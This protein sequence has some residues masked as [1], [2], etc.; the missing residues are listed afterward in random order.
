MG[1]SE[2]RGAVERLPVKSLYMKGFHLFPPIVRATRPLLRRL[3][4]LGPHIGPIMLNMA[5]L[6][7]K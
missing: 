4:R 2:M 1:W 3:D 6:A 5:V 7:R